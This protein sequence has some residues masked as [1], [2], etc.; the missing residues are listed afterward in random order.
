VPSS[1]GD[2]RRRRGKHDAFTDGRAGAGQAPEVDGVVYLSDAAASPGDIVRAR[3][4]SYADYDLAAAI[5]EVV[6]PAR[7]LRLPVIA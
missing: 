6:R 4:T 1:C 7:S 3:V 5:L 2:A